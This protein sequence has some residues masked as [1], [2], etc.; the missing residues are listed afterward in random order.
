[1]GFFTPS[2]GA[3]SHNFSHNGALEFSGTRF[4]YDWDM[5]KKRGIDI[6]RLFRL[7]IQIGRERRMAW[8]AGLSPEEKR[9][10]DLTTKLMERDRLAKRFLRIIEV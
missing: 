4:V 8:Y 3:P 7:G 6:D 5:A 1:M 9:I 2:A 10:F